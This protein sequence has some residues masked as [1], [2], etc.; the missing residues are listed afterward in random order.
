MSYC[1]GNV[2]NVRRQ[3]QSVVG[4]GQVVE[5]IH[6]LLCHCQARCFL[7][8]LSNT[9]I[10]IVR[11]CRQQD[12][13]QIIYQIM[14]EKSRRHSF[15]L[16]LHFIIRLMF[17][18]CH[19]YLCRYLCDVQNSQSCSQMFSCFLLCLGSFYLT[20]KLGIINTS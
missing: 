3:Y 8:I 5:G 18:F 15:M 11:K 20:G 6:V 14:I 1:R 4:L 12:N 2:S 9:H 10:F 17:N 7:P 19:F 16:S 13:R